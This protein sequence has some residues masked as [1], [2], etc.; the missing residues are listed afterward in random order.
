MLK[1]TISR[2]LKRDF[3]ELTMN[4]GMLNRDFT[5]TDTAARIDAAVSV[6]Q[7][8]RMCEPMQPQ[9]WMVAVYS[10]RGSS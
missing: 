4:F 9:V 3:R 2:F 1:D 8:S 7:R 5:K 10:Q 6:S